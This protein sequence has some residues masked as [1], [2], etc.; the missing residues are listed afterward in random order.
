[1]AGLGGA[2]LPG[3]AAF[4]TERTDASAIAPLIFLT[5]LAVLIVYEVMMRYQSSAR[6]VIP[7]P[8]GD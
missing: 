6:R 8:A 3:V 5:V 1:M 2:V 7:A 4:V